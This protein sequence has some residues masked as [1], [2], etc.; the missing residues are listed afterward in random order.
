M[1]GVH[2][3]VAGI[4]IAASIAFAVIAVIMILI[5]MIISWSSGKKTVED[6]GSPVA[7][8]EPKKEAATEKKSEEK[9]PTAETPKFS[10]WI[11]FLTFWPISFFV[12]AY[13]S[14]PYTAH[15]IAILIAV[16]L[17]WIVPLLF[18]FAK[19]AGRRLWWG[20]TVMALLVTLGSYA[21]FAH[22]DG[23]SETNTAIV[24]AA[25]EWLELATTRPAPPVRLCTR[26]HYVEGTISSTSEYTRFPA[27][28]RCREFRPEKSVGIPVQVRYNNGPWLVWESGNAPISHET[29]RYMDV[30]LINPGAAYVKVT[31]GS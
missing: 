3:I 5:R 2:P 4:L 21:F 12:Y 18:S 31:F 29:I 15:V 6:P 24:N 26:A 11:F 28:L 10:W 16:L 9:K 8:D 7:P 23:L 20:L 17:G 22:R 13:T 1:F 30:R 25:E 19:R 27:D 14:L